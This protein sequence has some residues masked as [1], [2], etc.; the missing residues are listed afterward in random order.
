M[1]QFHLRRIIAEAV[2]MHSAFH[3]EHNRRLQL[4]AN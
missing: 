4:N 1:N 2:L 3:G